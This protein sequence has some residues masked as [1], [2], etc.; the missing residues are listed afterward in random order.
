LTGDHDRIETFRKRAA[1]RKTASN[2]P[3][4]LGMVRAKEDRNEGEE[5]GDG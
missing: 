4:L 2:R 1:W 5:S 3:D